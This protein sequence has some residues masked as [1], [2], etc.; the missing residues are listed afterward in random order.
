MS[1]SSVNKIFRKPVS[2]VRLAL[3]QHLLEKNI[4]RGEQSQL[5]YIFVNSIL[6]KIQSPENATRITF[7]DLLVHYQ[8]LVV[9]VHE[10]LF[11]V[12]LTEIPPTFRF[13]FQ[14]S[15]QFLFFRKL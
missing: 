7:H 1:P 6:T 11:V 14:Q 15:A 3:K 9:L 10:F 13:F 2:E 5:Y 4:N 12:Y 8:C